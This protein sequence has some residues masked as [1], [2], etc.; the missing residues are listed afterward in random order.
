MGLCVRSCVALGWALLCLAG[1]LLI[2]APGPSRPLYFAG[3]VL[4]EC[5]LVVTAAGG[6]GLGVAALAGHAGAPSQTVTYLGADASSVRRLDM[7]LVPEGAGAR[8]RRHPAVVLVHGGGVG[9]GQPGRQPASGMARWPRVRGLRYRLPACHAHQPE[10]AAGDRGRQMRGRMGQR[11]R[12][13][14]RGRPRTHR[15]A[16]TRRCTP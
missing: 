2:V 4:T 3:V 11:P 5:S 14:L 6:V 16:R 12:C 7:W 9:P 10:L 1:G 15:P 8:G 13:A